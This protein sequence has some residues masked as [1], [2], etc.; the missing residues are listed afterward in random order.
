[1]NDLTRLQSKGLCYYRIRCTTWFNRSVMTKKAIFLS[2]VLTT[3]S[4][5]FFFLFG[6]HEMKNLTLA[7]FL[8]SCVFGGFFLLGLSLGAGW[9]CDW[10]EQINEKQY[11]NLLPR[12][13]N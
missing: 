10:R 5:V 12:N 7:G 11:K 8:G 4:I 6:C 9:F 3:L 2:G 13:I 1:M